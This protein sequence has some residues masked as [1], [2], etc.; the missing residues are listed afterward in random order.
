MLCCA[1]CAVLQ[2][3]NTRE[4]MQQA[5]DQ[6]VAKL[7]W[8]HPVSPEADLASAENMFFAVFTVESNP[9]ER[10]PAHEHF[11]GAA[12]QNYSTCTSTVAATA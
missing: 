9:P 12:M 5:F 11:C 8:E 10:Q 6:G 2:W 3:Q 1:R 7:H 4:Q